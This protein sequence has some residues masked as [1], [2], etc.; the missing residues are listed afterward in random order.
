MTAA[1][2]RT[3]MHGHMHMCMDMYM[4]ICMYMHMYMDMSHVY[5]MFMSMSMFM[6]T[7]M[8]TCQNMPTCQQAC[9]RYVVGVFRQV[10]P[11]QLHLEYTDEGGQQWIITSKTS[12][13][14]I[15]RCKALRVKIR[16]LVPQ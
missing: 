5:A 15:S 6:F 4:H 2:T 7:S 14:E 1:H 11:R 8:P 3:H 9:L 16:S 13:E 10:K 12:V